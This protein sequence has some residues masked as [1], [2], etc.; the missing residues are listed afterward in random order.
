MTPQGPPGAASV[1]ENSIFIAIVQAKKTS[2]SIRDEPSLWKSS[3]MRE[4]DLCGTWRRLADKR[5]EL[6]EVHIPT[7][8]DSGWPQV[9]VPDNFGLDGELQRFEDDV[10]RENGR[11]PIFP[12]H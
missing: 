9:N 8:D 3:D 12:G 11:L 1:S 6:K 7:Y 5:G 2:Y 4:V 10:L